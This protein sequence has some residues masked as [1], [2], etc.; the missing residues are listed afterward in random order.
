MSNVKRR[1][2]LQ[3]LNIFQPVPQSCPKNI[4][5]LKRFYEPF[6]KK[7]SLNVMDHNEEFSFL[8]ERTEPSD[9]LM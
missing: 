3:H 2:H 8:K 1:I 4:Y 7:V 5:Y 9:D 6:K